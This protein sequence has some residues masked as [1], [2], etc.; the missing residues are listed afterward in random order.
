[1][2]LNTGRAERAAEVPLFSRRLDVLQPWTAQT[3]SG[4]DAVDWDGDGREDV[5]TGQGHAGSG[6]RFYARG[7]L[8]AVRRDAA[9]AHRGRVRRATMTAVKGTVRYMKSAAD[10][11]RWLEA[12]HADTT[13]IWLLGSTGRTRA[14]RAS[15]TR[16]R[17][18]RRCASVG[19]TACARG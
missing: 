10:F 2:F 9:A 4:A 19:S 15:P 17:W 13:E 14:C 6:V 7:Y 5:L 18:T 8:D 11:R 16:R 12:H 3:I 1:M